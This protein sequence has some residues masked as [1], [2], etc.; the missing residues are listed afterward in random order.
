MEIRAS[1]SKPNRAT[2]VSSSLNKDS[3]PRPV[4]KRVKTAK[5]V[6]TRQA[7]GNIPGTKRSSGGASSRNQ[8]ATRSRASSINRTSAI[9][10]H[11]SNRAGNNR[12]DTRRRGSPISVHNKAAS[13]TAQAPGSGGA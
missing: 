10:S 5:A 4:A 6:N 9:N 12:A 7:T 11:H 3:P 1:S 2:G 8:I 13:Q